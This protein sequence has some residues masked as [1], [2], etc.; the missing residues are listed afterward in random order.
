MTAELTE[1]DAATL[2]KL[3]AL[4]GLDLAPD[5]AAALAG[6]VAALA[7]ADRRLAALNLGAAPASGPP[8]GRSDD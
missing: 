1:P 2:Q 5:H 8:W 3:A 7:R 4:A 6:D